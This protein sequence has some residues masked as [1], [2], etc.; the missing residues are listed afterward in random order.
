MAAAANMYKS[1]GMQYSGALHV[2]MLLLLIFGLPSFLHRHIDAPPPAISVD[3]LPLAPISNVKP[4]EK[5]PE[6]IEKKPELEKITEK[7]PTPETSKV[8]QK[9]EAE[10]VK[11]P[12]KDV[13]KPDKPK[14]IKKDKPKPKEDSLESILKSVKDTAK[15]D[16]AKKPTQ[17]KAQPNTH[18]AVSQTYDSSQ[19]LSMSE[20]DAIRNQIQKCWDVPAG[21]RDA[22][23]LVVTLH[24]D[25]NQDGTVTNVKLAQD[26]GR[27]GSD[28]FFRAAADSAMR[29]VNRCSPLKDLPADKYSRWSSMSMTFDPKDMLY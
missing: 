22:Q 16:Q 26:E 10:P 1:H 9:T 4:Q 19:P 24:I 23:N 27:Y 6:K 20:L 29:A 13:V 2:A 12:A 7:K 28:S 18:Q 25:V 5:T 8:Q 11:I 17:T 15:A 14:P 21:A 3:I